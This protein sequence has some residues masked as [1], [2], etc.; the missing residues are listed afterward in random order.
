MSISRTLGPIPLLT[1]V[2]GG[3]AR[4]TRCRNPSIS[5]VPIIKPRGGGV[6]GFPDFQEKSELIFVLGNAMGLPVQS[7]KKKR[8][9]CLEKRMNLWSRL[10]PRCF[11]I[12]GMF[13][14]P[15][16][17]EGSLKR[18]AVS[19]KEG[20]KNRAPQTEVK[21]PC[22]LGLENHPL[23]GQPLTASFD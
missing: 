7:V 11:L 3:L 17:T 16:L 19:G 5:K 2:G 13:G 22:G 18:S 10:D 20:E 12:W 21:S 23:Y 6:Q 9:E 4:V 1:E 8:A 14:I 15:R